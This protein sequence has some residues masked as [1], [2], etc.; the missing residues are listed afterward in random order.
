MHT[1]LI[2]DFTVTAINMT[3]SKR[4]DE[5]IDV[6]G[7]EI[8]AYGCPQYCE[9][10]IQA[11]LKKS[12]SPSKEQDGANHSKENKWYRYTFYISFISR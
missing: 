9:A 8:S 7:D 11:V 2:Y 3:T 12:P 10:D 5:E 4:R 1:N 6:D